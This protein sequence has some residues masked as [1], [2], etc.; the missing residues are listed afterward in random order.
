M[1]YVEKEQFPTYYQNIEKNNN[2]N[3][4]T[5]ELL[6]FMQ[7]HEGQYPSLY[8]EDENEKSLA[9]Q[10]IIY[11]EDEKTAQRF[12][13]LK[14][15]KDNKLYNPQNIMYKLA[16]ERKKQNETKIV[17]LRC[18]EFLQKYGRRPLPNS[19]NQDESQLAIEYENKCIKKLENGE[20]AI[21]NNMF[22]NRKNFQKTCDEYIK[23]IKASQDLEINH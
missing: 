7:Q 15:D 23:N 11:T 5:I 13:L 2:I 1:K 10:F 6:E 19:N 3:E 4:F 22:N 8:S 20:I 9:K 16:L 18:V 17:I 14:K 21:L 12:N